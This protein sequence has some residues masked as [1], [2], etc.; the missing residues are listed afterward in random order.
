[1]I[2]F[3]IPSPQRFWPHA[4]SWRLQGLCVFHLSCQCEPQLPL[5]W[6]S[7]LN[8]GWHFQV[9]IKR[10]IGFSSLQFWPCLTVRGGV[11]KRLRKQFGAFHPGELRY[12]ISTIQFHETKQFWWIRVRKFPFLCSSP[13]IP[14]HRYQR[15][16]AKRTFWLTKYRFAMPKLP[17][18]PNHLTLKSCAS[19]IFFWVA[20]K[21]SSPFQMIGFF[22]RS[23]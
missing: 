6:Y 21:L 2:K 19:R 18:S 14:P 16:L 8:N 3:S 10:C 4:S 12:K 5:V 17:K 1:M 23:I 9:G 22:T 20:R 15:E 11:L 7:L 13:Q